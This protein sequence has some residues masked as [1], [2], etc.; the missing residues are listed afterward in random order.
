M[1]KVLIFVTMSRWDE[2]HRGRHHYAMLLSKR[3]TVI[4]VDRH[5]KP[6][7]DCVKYGL[8]H[9][10]DG[11]FV[12]HVGKQI[13]PARL[14]DQL[15]INNCFRLRLLRR[16]MKRLNIGIPDVVWCYDYKAMPF[17]KAFKHQSV[18]IYFCNDWFGEWTHRF[19]TWASPMYEAK[20]ASTVNHVISISPNLRDRF[21][22]LN[23]NSH[24]VPHGLWLPEGRPVFRKKKQPEIIGYVGTLNNTID[25]DFLQRILDETEFK[26]L[27]AGPVIEA[28]AFKKIELERLIRHPKVKYLG[29]LDR[30]GADNARSL[31]DVLLL[32]YCKGKVREWGFPIKYFEYLGSG[33]VIVSTECMEWPTEFCETVHIYRKHDDIQMCIDQAYQQWD[34]DRFNHSI[35]LAC[36]STWEKRVA[37][38][39]ELIHVEL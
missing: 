3:N 24:F 16:E 32:P 20:L 13:F 8:E 5:L 23:P 37:R 35:K 28:S 19:G 21:I 38:V 33:K 30:R 22:P 29:N 2:P 26:L 27:L 36:K 17:V 1:K 18:C 4:W 9:I 12:L 11:L 6:E 7:E 15:N 14:D 39:S 25:I 34:E 31:M 10:E